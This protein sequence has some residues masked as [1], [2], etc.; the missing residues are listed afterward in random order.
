MQNAHISALAIK[1]A[2]L[3]ARIAEENHR[4]HPDTATLARLKKEKL[5]VKEVITGLAH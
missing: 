1:H 3:D 2:D 4:P 5:K